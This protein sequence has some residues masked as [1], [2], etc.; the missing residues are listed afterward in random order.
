MRK[1]YSIL[2]L[3]FLLLVNTIHAR[4]KVQVY[5]GG[6]S[7]GSILPNETITNSLLKDNGG[8]SYI[9]Q[10]LVN[11]SKVL[12]NK[13]F[14][15]SYDFLKDGISEEDQNIMVLALDGEYIDSISIKS[16]NLT[17][18]DIIL[19]FQIIFFN[20]KTN[21]L[22][23]SIPLEI[24]KNISSNNK[25]SKDQ[26]KQELKT[27]YEN[28]VAKYYFDL[29][30]NFNL[31]NKYKNRIGVTNVIFE[32]NAKEY[33]KKNMNKEDIFLK[34]RFAKSLSSFIAFNNDVAIVPFAQ[35]RSSNTIML[36]FENSQREINLPNPDYHIHLTIRGFKS[37]LF[38][39]SNINEQWIYGSYTNIKILQPDY[40]DEQKRIKMDE[41][42]KSGL[43][44]ELSKRSLDNKQSFEW[45]FYNDSLKVLFDNFSKQTVELDKKWLK[46]S[47]GNKKISKKFKEI[48][49]IYDR[50][51]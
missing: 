37:V 51:K 23:A 24:S 18:T 46:S 6:F 40:P 25:L 11:K 2:L 28:E 34:N 15:L 42:F 30:K 9:N 47:N 14:D 5:D 4:A 39:E 22:V 7:F 19:N 49:E 29:L 35:D 31:Q 38:K 21:S 45:I 3:F 1:A 13:S 36:R 20:A 12:S 32:D 43:N 44:V 8:V 26:I 27:M 10:L 41:K 16:D 17:R 50:C 33:F 48:K